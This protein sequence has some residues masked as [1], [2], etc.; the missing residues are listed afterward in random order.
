[1]APH[2]SSVY[3]FA[4]PYEIPGESIESDNSKNEDIDMDYSQYLHV[5]LDNSLTPSL[6]FSYSSTSGSSDF[7][8]TSSSESESRR[9]GLA[10]KAPR[11]CT[12]KQPLTAL[13][14]QPGTPIFAHGVVDNCIDPRLAVSDTDSSDGWDMSQSPYLNDSEQVT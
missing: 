7:S 4:W 1:M 2:A 12:N 10:G 11:T 3:D 14:R 6:Y 13:L 5:Y 9:G 8:G